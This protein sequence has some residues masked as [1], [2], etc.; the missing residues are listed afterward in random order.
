MNGWKKFLRAY[1]TMF[2]WAMRVVAGLIA[3]ANLAMFVFVII[4]LANKGGR[5]GFAGVVFIV[6]S[7]ALA[8]AMWK[9]GSVGLLRLRRAKAE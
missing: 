7:L 9:V 8:L 3:A 5:Y 1:Y 6:I 2:F 4:D